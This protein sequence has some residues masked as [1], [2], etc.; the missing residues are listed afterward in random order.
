MDVVILVIF[1]YPIKVFRYFFAMKSCS[2][3]EIARELTLIR[4]RWKTRMETSIN[5]K[6]LKHY[7]QT[8]GQNINRIEAHLLR[9]S[10]QKNGVISQD[11]WTDI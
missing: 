8:D 7:R 3:G 9:E 2:A 6:A 11:R 5:S 4:L 1:T 10:A